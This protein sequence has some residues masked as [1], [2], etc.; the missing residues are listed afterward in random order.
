MVYTFPETATI[1]PDGSYTGFAW[2]VGAGFAYELG[3]DIELEI[4]Y[5]HTDLG[6]VNTDIGTMKIVNHSMGE[7]INDSIIINGTKADLT[8]NEALLSIVWFF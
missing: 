1:T 3:E 5:R 8:V 4:V 7:I 2:A 6:Q